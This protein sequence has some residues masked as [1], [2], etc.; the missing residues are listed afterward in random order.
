M[1]FYLKEFPLGE[2]S[3]EH[4]V[5]GLEFLYFEISHEIPTVFMDAWF[6]Y[7]GGLETILAVST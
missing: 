2:L 1:L 5:D 6:E 7:W 4:I 3:L